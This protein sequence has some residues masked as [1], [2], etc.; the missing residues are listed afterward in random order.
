MECELRSQR[1]LA[2]KGCRKIA[3]LQ[4]WF[5]TSEFVLHLADRDKYEPTAKSA[6]DPQ[7]SLLNSDG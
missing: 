6:E 3:A 2:Q 4:E 5:G 1:A 7:I